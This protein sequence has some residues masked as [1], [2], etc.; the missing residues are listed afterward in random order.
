MGLIVV[1]PET[2]A[3]EHMARR[4]RHSRVRFRTPRVYPLGGVPV[5]RDDFGVDGEIVVHVVG[6]AADH[7]Y[8]VWYDTSA[9]TL[10]FFRPSSGPVREV[11]VGADLGGV[12]IDCD[13]LTMA[14]ATASQDTEVH[15]T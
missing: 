15:N 1:I 5:E 2:P 12:V 10:R 11:E 9:G 3:R 8:Q 6:T 4:I 7:R 13:V 14:P